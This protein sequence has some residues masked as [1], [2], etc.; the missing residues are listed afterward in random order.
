MIRQNTFIKYTPSDVFLTIFGTREGGKTSGKSILFLLKTTKC[1]AVQNSSM[2]RAPSLS[3][4]DNCL[5]R[6]FKEDEDQLN[7][8]KNKEQLKTLSKK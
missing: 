7:S 4:S 5:K 1:I 6:Y 2:L 8:N 3:I